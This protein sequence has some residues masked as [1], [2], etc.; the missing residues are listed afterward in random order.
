MGLHVLQ[1][2]HASFCVSIFACIFV[3]CNPQVFEVHDCFSCNELFMY[4][5]LQCVPEGQ[6]LQMMQQSSWRQ[7]KE[8][9]QLLYLN[10]K[11]VFNPSGGLESK[12]HPIG[13]TGE[14]VS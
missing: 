2:L 10:N 13:A 1:F 3:W 8:G 7:N 11:W 12:G 5:A 9:G 6:G 4:E 14:C